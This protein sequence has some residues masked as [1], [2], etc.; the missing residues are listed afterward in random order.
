MCFG[1]LEKVIPK[2]FVEFL[3]LTVSDHPR[4]T[5]KLFWYLWKSIAM[6]SYDRHS[7]LPRLRPSQWHIL[8]NGQPKACLLPRLRSI[9]V[10][11]NMLTRNG[12]FYDLKIRRYSESTTERG[13]CGRLRKRM[14]AGRGEAQS[15]QFD[16][17]ID[18][19]VVETQASPTI[20]SSRSRRAIQGSQ[21]FPADTSR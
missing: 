2:R 14:G 7:I 4:E 21:V 19:P 16:T 20:E 6:S 11:T 18:T 9:G 10:L 1:C 5:G 8:L 17:R 12:V 15:R 13:T 3:E